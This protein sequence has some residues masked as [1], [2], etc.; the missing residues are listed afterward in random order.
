LAFNLDDI[1]L[2]ARGAGRPESPIDYATVERAAAIG[3]T[4]E[5]IAV[6]C[7]IS[8]AT[9]YNRMETDPE[10]AAA[11]ER[12]QDGGKATLRRLQWKGANDGNPT[13]LIWLGKMMLGQREIQNLQN[14]DKDGKPTDPPTHTIIRLVG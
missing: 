11:I 14:L 8:R 7:G 13:M 3:C 2:P 10:I 1:E 5:E 9:L 4:K 6:V 12:G